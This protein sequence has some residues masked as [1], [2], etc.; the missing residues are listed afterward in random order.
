V[1]GFFYACDYGVSVDE[2]KAIKWRRKAAKKEQPS[3]E[4]NLGEAYITGCGGVKEN[5]EKAIKW[6]KSAAKHGHK[7][8]QE[9]FS[10]IEK[11][12]FENVKKYLYPKIP[13]CRWR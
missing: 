11:R 9:I 5:K 4:F 7:P 3:A 13:F 12:G 1:L 6:I 10:K 2:A 8:A